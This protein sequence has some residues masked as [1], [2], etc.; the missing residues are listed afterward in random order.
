[1]HRC[2]HNISTYIYA[3]IYTRS[4]CMYVYI[5]IYIDF[6]ALNIYLQNAQAYILKG[7]SASN[8]VRPKPT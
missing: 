8:V 3:Q 6:A 2:I 4:V 5:Y 7:I 1:M